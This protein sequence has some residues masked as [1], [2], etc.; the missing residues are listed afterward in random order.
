MRT[1]LFSLKLA[2]NYQMRRIFVRRI[3]AAQFRSVPVQYFGMISIMLWNSNRL[4]GLWE[5]RFGCLSG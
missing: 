1:N 5:P 2:V 3:F 4:L